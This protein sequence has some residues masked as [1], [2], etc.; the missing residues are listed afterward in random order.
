MTSLSHIPFG[1][2]KGK[3]GKKGGRGKGRD[4]CTVYRMGWR[5]IQTNELIK[6]RKSYS[7]T[8]ISFLLIY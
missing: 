7:P 6:M 2:K 3:E 8:K 5:E 4:I 1:L